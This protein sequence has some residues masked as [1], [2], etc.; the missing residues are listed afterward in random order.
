MLSE[1]SQQ[2]LV[3]LW[4]KDQERNLCFSLRLH[5]YSIEEA[6]KRTKTQ[7]LIKLISPFVFNDMCHIILKSSFQAKNP[8]ADL[9][10][11]ISQWQNYSLASAY[12]PKTKF[13]WGRKFKSGNIQKISFSL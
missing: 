1:N 5:F 8:G 7:K 13:F 4:T 6:K 11:N 9:Y 10:S 3:M 2:K 12:Y